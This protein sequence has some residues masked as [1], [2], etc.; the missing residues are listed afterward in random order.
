MSRIYEPDPGVHVNDV[1][2]KGMPVLLNEVAN[3]CMACATDNIN[4]LDFMEPA[5]TEVVYMAEVNCK[6]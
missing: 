5:H 2:I 3:V 1:T 4:V 6:T